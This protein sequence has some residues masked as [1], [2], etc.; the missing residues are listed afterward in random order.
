MKLYIKIFLAFVAVSAVSIAAV[1]AAVGV[2]VATE[3]RSYNALYSSRAQRTAQ[4]LIDYYADNQGWDD[5]QSV[6]S[7]ITP[8]GRGPGQGQGAHIGVTNTDNWSYQ[9]ADTGGQVVADLSGTPA[10]M[11]KK[12]EM[13]DA[14]PLTLD[15]VT[16]GYIALTD[17][18]PLEQPAVDFLRGLQNAVWLSAGIAL[19]TALIAAGLLARGITAPVRTL[20]VAAAAIADGDLESRAAVSGNDEITQLAQTF[21]VMAD[22]LQRAEQSRKMQTADIAHELRN[23]LAVLQGSLEALADGIY[24]PTPENINPALDQVRTLNRLVEDLRI[25]ASAEA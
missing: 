5:L 23:P 4:A 6:I 22:N 7:E 18:N 25:L 15:G 9:V 8:T 24:E 10:G 20:T 1:A 14:L 3:F 2:L 13:R 12:S 21:N 19:V 16:I 11:L 17:Q